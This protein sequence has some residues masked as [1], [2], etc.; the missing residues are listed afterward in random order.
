MKWFSIKSLYNTTFYRKTLDV[1][2]DEIFY[3]FYTDYRG[4]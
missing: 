2:S 1:S 4:D 3:D